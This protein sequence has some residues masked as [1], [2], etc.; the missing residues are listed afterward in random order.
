MTDR[1]KARAL[2][3]AGEC[4]NMADAKAYLE[5]MGELEDDGTLDGVGD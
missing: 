1:E 3:D 2:V 4:E 5:D